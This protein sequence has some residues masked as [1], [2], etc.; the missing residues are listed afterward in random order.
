MFGGGC[1][2]ERVP[3][4][5]GY[6]FFPLRQWHDFLSLTWSTFSRSWIAQTNHGFVIGHGGSTRTAMRTPRTMA[7]AYICTSC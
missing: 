1:L 7:S 6:H 3:L 5:L 2:G 4:T